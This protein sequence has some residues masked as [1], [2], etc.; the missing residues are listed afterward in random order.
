MSTETELTE[1]ELRIWIAEKTG[2][3]V[4]EMDSPQY[5]SEAGQIGP[6]AIKRHFKFYR[7]TP[8]PGSKL[9]RIHNNGMDGWGVSVESAAWHLPDYTRDLN[10]MAEAVKILTSTERETYIQAL[11]RITFQFTFMP[12]SNEEKLSWMTEAS[13]TDRAK[14]FYLAT[15][16]KSK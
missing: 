14:A 13:A 1:E 9:A 2:W 5:V 8:P 4:E 15:K 3:T 6:P 10:A 12:A 11:V 16:C 7:W